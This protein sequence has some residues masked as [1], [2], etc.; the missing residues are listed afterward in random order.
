MGKNIYKGCQKK[1][2][3]EQLTITDLNAEELLDALGKHRGM[4]QGGAYL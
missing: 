2:Y 3:Q 4:I 1:E